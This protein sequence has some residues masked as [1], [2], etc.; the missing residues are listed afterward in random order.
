MCILLWIQKL[1]QRTLWIV[2]TTLSKLPKKQMAIDANN[3]K[4]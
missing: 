1:Q 2:S 3:L 4:I